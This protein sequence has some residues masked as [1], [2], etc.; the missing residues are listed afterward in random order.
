MAFGCFEG[1]GDSNYYWTA[2]GGSDNYLAL[3]MS[4]LNT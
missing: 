2:F 3:K 4:I 1:S